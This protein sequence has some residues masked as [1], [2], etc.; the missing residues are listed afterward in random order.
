[1]KIVLMV[2][3]YFSGEDNMLPSRDEAQRLWDSL[4]NCKVRY[5][6]DHGH[7][8]LLV[9]GIKNCHFTCNFAL[10]SCSLGVLI[11]SQNITPCISFFEQ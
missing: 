7:T 4:R 10:G 11:M 2:Y 9:G 8:L 5:F 6:K 3:L 1:M